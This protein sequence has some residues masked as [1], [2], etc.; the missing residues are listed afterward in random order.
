MKKQFTILLFL[1]A[2]FIFLPTISL[3]KID[4]SNIN[5]I[6]QVKIWDTYRS[7]YISTGSGV[8]FDGALN[9]LTNYHVVEDAII[10]PARYL[11][12][13]CITKNSLSASD[14]KYVYSVYGIWGNK[15]KVVKEL[16]LAILSLEGIIKDGK[17]I[18]VLQMTGTDLP[19]GSSNIKISIYGEE[20]T[21]IKI[22]DQVQT[23]GYPGEGGDTITY[24]NGAVTN[25]EMNKDGRVLAIVTSARIT[26]GSSGGAAFDSYGKF[27]GITSAMYADSSGN[28]ISGVIIPVTTIN[29]W[30]KEAQGYRVKK[31]GEYTIFDEV[32]EEVMQKAICLMNGSEKYHYDETSKTCVCNSGYSKNSKGVCEKEQRTSCPEGFIVGRNRCVTLDK[33]C[34]DVYGP[35]IYS[36]GTFEGYTL[37]G[38]KDGYDWNFNQ[39]S[40]N[41]FPPEGAVI[42]TVGDIDVYIV[43]YVGTKKFKR[44]VLSPDVFNNYGHLKW[45]NV[46]DVNKSIVDSFTTSDLVRAAGDDKVYKLSASGDAGQKRL[47]K[48]SAVLTKFGLDAD[49]IYEINSFDRD[50]YVAGLDLE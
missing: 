6:V 22:G 48:N 46:M 25:F 38:C 12:I 42:R 34:T 45:E 21:G 20:L 2:V 19:L 16:D 41:I 10:N 35:N 47:I 3:A 14:C 32:T 49:S 39:T 27:I 50:S 36:K 7:E 28:F 23:L 17:I 40:C 31:D 8:F 13:I 26:P 4:D 11:S 9:I 44:L 30:L 24:S 33:N 5:A 37:C 1:S 18:N 43:K 15:P 29:W